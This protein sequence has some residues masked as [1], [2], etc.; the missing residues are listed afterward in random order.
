MNNE[1]YEAGYDAYWDGVDISDDP[2]DRET[3]A[4]EF[5]DWEQGWRK[6]RDHDYDEREG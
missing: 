2:Y 3:Q 5:Q 4:K 6:A 1:A